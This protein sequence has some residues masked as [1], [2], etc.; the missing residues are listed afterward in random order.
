[1]ATT[2]RPFSEE[3][4]LDRRYLRIDKEVPQ[5]AKLT[6]LFS[7]VKIRPDVGIYD[8]DVP[9]MMLEVHSS[10][11]NETLDKLAWDLLEQL[12]WLR[13]CD[14]KITEWSGFCFPK[15][16][17]DSCVSQMDI[18]WDET[19]MN[20]AIDYVPVEKSRVRKA[21][22]DTHCDLVK[23]HIFKVPDEILYGI[24]LSRLD[25]HFGTNA[26]QVPSNH[27]IV[28]SSDHC[29][30]KMIPDPKEEANVMKLLFYKM[31]SPG[32]KRY[33]LPTSIVQFGS[34]E[35]LVFP[36]LLDPMSAVE[37]Q[38]SFPSF[39]RSVVDAIE[40]LHQ[41]LKLA[42]VDIRLDNICFSPEEP[43]KGKISI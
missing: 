4:P 34:H 43:T 33:S 5:L 37:V 26:F 40:A 2:T 20:F 42:H 10:P 6:P 25:M 38:K 41:E 22:K 28:V 1:M 30:Y 18:T 21:I 36:K 19:E 24:P 29:I 39:V 14:P 15:H 16:G 17:A 27:S 3:L 11:Y 35:F 12:R 9:L 31:G 13:N 23:K 7:S 32:P 8:L